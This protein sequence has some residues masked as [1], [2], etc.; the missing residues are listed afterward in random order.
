MIVK[1]GVGGQCVRMR[2]M[3][4]TSSQM[5]TQYGGSLYVV[6]RSGSVAGGG[7]GKVCTVCPMFMIFT[8]LLLRCCCYSSMFP[9]VVFCISGR[10]SSVMVRRLWG[11]FV[12]KH[13]VRRP[14][15][16]VELEIL[17][18][19]IN[20]IIHYMRSH[21]IECVRCMGTQVRSRLYQ[22]LQETEYYSK[23]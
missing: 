10:Q 19:F 3:L 6:H 1:W 16:C 9:W 11:S 17:I 12:T 14:A 5:Y 4:A 7:R 13:G 23:L 18:M 8:V 22:M 2:R 20:L 21:I 15:V